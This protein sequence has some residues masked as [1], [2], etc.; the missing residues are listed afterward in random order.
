[1]G[2]NGKTYKAKRG[3]YKTWKLPSVRTKRAT[4]KCQGGRENPGKRNMIKRP[5]EARIR[6]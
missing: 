6:G 2:Q 1:V 5:K 3:K 4:P